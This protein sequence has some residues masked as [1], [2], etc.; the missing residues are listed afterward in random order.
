MSTIMVNVARP[1]TT[2]PRQDKAHD[3]F[4]SG[5]TQGWSRLVA[6]LVAL[7]HGIGLVLPLG[8]LAL[9]AGLAAYAVV[10]RFMPRHVPYTSE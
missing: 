7:A 1:S 4:L 6:F 10:R 5:L 8:A 2:P 3:G 9:C